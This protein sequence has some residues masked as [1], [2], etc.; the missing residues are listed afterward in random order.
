MCWVG[1]S[2]FVSG[3]VSATSFDVFGVLGGSR[4]IPK[5]QKRPLAASYLSVW[6]LLVLVYILAPFFDKK[7]YYF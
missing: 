6:T 3:C 2:L 7:A 1:W 4:A 5:R